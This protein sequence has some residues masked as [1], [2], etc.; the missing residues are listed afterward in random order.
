MSRSTKRRSR[1]LVLT[2]GASVIA[3]AS[4]AACVTNLSYRYDPNAE[5]GTSE[6]G[7]ADA[8]R[9]DSGPSG[10]C[11]R[12]LL[13]GGNAPEGGPPKKSAFYGAISG[14]QVH[15][16]IAPP[17]P[18]AS[19]GGGGLLVG[20]RVVLAGGTDHFDQYTA[21]RGKA[22]GPAQTL[23]GKGAGC[24]MG[25]LRPQQIHLLCGNDD[26][27]DGGYQSAFYGADDGNDVVWTN[28]KPSEQL[29]LG[30][31][32]VPIADRWLVV[33]PGGAA[34]LGTPQVDAQKIDWVA[35]T[36]RPGLPVGGCAVAVDDRAYFIGGDN[37]ATVE[38]AVLTGD[39]LS[40]A[41]PAKPLPENRAGAACLYAGGRIWVFGG[42]RTGKDFTDSVYSA[43]V[44]ETGLEAEWTL[45]DERIPNLVFGAT[46]ACLP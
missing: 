42:A 38:V 16:T 44:T 28:A 25:S 6:G 21:F 35:A 43:R 19:A 7:G 9:N 34:H 31:L 4:L 11:R 13:V 46:V 22:W 29:Q 18:Y 1:L 14:T 17:L 41:P 30:S 26:D 20:D 2:G 37:A 12:I 15:W 5:G 10:S 36:N 27:P 23:P 24:T 40:W 8:P 39:T 32:A 3:L 33:S 45:A